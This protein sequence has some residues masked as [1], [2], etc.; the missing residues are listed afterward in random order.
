M[1]LVIFFHVCFRYLHRP[2][3]VLGYKF[4]DAVWDLHLV[5]V[6]SDLSYSTS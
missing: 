5:D 1:F 4:G 3:H 2:T 6:A